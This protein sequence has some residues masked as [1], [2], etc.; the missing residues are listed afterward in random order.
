MIAELKK[1][2]NST[3]M[4]GYFCDAHSPWQKGTNGNI[5]G[6]IRGFF[7]KGT[8]FKLVTKQKI[9]WVQEALNERPRQILDFNTPKDVLNSL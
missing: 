4:Q 6:L 8:D 9:V 5:N 1:F 7:S 3:K 2:T